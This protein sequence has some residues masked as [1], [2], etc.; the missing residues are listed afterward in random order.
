MTVQDDYITLTYQRAFSVLNTNQ[1]PCIK[2][3]KSEFAEQ[4]A[5][6]RPF[7]SHPNVKEDKAIWIR[8]LGLDIVILTIHLPCSI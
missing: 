7:S 3:P 5:F 8:K 2:S 4:R 6:T 1:K